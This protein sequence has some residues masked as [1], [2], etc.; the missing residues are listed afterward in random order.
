MESLLQVNG[1]TKWPK[2]LPL[3]K[4]PSVAMEICGAL[5]KN[6]FFHRSEKIDGKKGFLRVSNRQVF[7][8]TGYY[9]WMYSG[10]MVWSNVATLGVIAVVIIFTLLP[11]WPDAAKRVLWWI[12]VTFL[13]FLFAFLMVRLFLFLFL[14]IAGYDFWVFPRLFD[15][16]LGVT[17]SFKPAYSFEKGAAGQGYYRVGL[18]VAFAGFVAWAMSQPT[19]FEGFLQAQKVFVD[20]LYSGNLLADVAAHREHLENQERTKR[21]PKI[22]QLLRE[23]EEEEMAERAATE[24]GEDGEGGAATGASSASSSDGEGHGQD[25]MDDARMDEMLRSHE[26]EDAADEE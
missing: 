18:L 2:S 23:M 5:L 13:L 16:T 9:T 19:E 20:D 15:E 25:A 24:G 6:Q 26:E 8:E 14:W 10:S 22:E 4:E 17:D 1:G 7:E 21:F 12:S 3:I 11:V